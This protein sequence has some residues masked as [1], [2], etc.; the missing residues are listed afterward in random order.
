MSASKRTCSFSGKRD[1][2]DENPTINLKERSMKKILSFL[3]MGAMVISAGAARASVADAGFVASK[4]GEKYHYASCPVAKKIAADKKV[5]FTVVDEAVKAGYSACKTCNP[6][7]SSDALVASKGSGKYHKQGCRLADG[8][9]AENKM[10]IKDAA[11]AAR[12]DYK[13]CQ[14]CLKDKAGAAAAEAAP[15]RKAVKARK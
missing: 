9:K 7:P 15:A 1:I 8:I 10:Y 2:T 12:V 5:V 6:P 14:V 3:I 4:G 13:P 11:E